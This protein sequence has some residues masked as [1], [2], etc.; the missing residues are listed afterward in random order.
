MRV[1]RRYR[2]SP[3]RVRH[4]AIYECDPFK[5]ASPFEI[6]EVECACAPPDKETSE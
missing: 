5:P 6:D 2:R 3:W 4:S 1:R